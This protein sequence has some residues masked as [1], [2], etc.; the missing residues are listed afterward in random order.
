MSFSV[1]WPQA[2]SSRSQIN[3]ACTAGDLLC[4]I[5]MCIHALCCAFVVMICFHYFQRHVQNVC[6]LH[7]SDWS[8]ECWWPM[9]SSEQISQKN[10]IFVLPLSLQAFVAMWIC[11]IEVGSTGAESLRVWNSQKAR[12]FC[13]LCFC[14]SANSRLW[15]HTKCIIWW[16]KQRVVSA[17]ICLKVLES[18]WCSQ[19]DGVQKKHQ[20]SAKCLEASADSSG[21]WTH[22]IFPL[23]AHQSLQHSSSIAR[24]H[25]QLG[26]KMM[27]FLMFWLIF[28]WW[29]PSTA[30]ARNPLWISRSQCMIAKL[31]LYLSEDSCWCSCNGIWKNKGRVP[32]RCWWRLICF[33]S[34]IYSNRWIL[35]L[36]ETFSIYADDIDISTIWR[37]WWFR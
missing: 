29:L 32:R 24:H 11:L 10:L 37:F 16:E 25:Q 7:L 27:I 21:T 3:G 2:T 33:F 9:S 15:R 35:H 18:V 31:Y 30:I 28:P 22:E 20:R 1:F 6:H 36:C 26:E 17:S 4:L 12:T 19:W 13:Y 34:I 14:G 5:A 23:Q 8:G